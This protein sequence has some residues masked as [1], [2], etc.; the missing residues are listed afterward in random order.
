MPSKERQIT[1]ATQNRWRTVY[2][3]RFCLV[4]GKSK[5]C[6]A[7][8]Y[9][10]VTHNRQTAKRRKGARYLGA[11]ITTTKHVG[12]DVAAL[13]KYKTQKLWVVRWERKALTRFMREHV[14]LLR[15]W[16]LSNRSDHNGQHWWEN[17]QRKKCKSPCVKCLEAFET[18]TLPRHQTL[19][20]ARVGEIRAS[21]AYELETKK[22]W[23]CWDPTRWKSNDMW[24][25]GSKTSKTV[26]DAKR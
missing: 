15:I 13:T 14:I 18:R 20:A 7:R 22:H 8:Y 19:N 12:I 25:T 4:L 6:S 9:V 16:R 24:T 2:K 5:K 26:G 10:R 11:F 17:M 21:A 3:T 23:T 1:R